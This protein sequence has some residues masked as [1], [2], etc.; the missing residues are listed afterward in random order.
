MFVEL[1]PVREDPEEEQE[2]GKTK[3]HNSRHD[4]DGVPNLPGGGCHEA[5]E[6]QAMQKRTSNECHTMG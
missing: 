3:Q 6:R 5:M 1:E 2:N 4:T